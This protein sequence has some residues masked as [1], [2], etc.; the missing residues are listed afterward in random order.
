M[1]ETGRRALPGVPDGSWSTRPAASGV[2]AEGGAWRRR[3]R[4]AGSRSSP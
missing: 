3:P 2:S 4:S 1:I